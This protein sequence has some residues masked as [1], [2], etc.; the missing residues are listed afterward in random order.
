MLQ[1]YE[2]CTVLGV[3]LTGVVG[4]VCGSGQWWC[5]VAVAEKLRDLGNA[6]DS[7]VD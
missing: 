3:R 4:A 5:L 2:A 6:R 1:G 7:I